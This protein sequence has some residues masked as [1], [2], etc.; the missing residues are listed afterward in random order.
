MGRRLLSPDQK[1]NRPNHLCERALLALSVLEILFV[2]YWP[3]LVVNC[4]QFLA[5]YVDNFMP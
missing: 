4:H 2:F 1:T 5:A 3:M